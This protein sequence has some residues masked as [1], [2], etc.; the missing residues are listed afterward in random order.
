LDK[1]VEMTSKSQTWPSPRRT[2]GFGKV[3][4]RK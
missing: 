3:R 2:S 1:V 4:A